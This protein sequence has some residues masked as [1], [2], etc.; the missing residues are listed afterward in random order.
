MEGATA[1]AAKQKAMS[2][3]FYL[4]SVGLLLLPF[5][6]LAADLEVTCVGSNGGISCDSN[7]P[8]GALFDEG[9]LLP[10]DTAIRSLRVNNNYD[11]PCGF[12][13]DTENEV[14]G[15]FSLADRLWTVIRSTVDRFGISDGSGGATNNKTMSNVFAAGP[16]ALGTLAANSTKNYEWA[17]TFDETT[18]NDWQGEE[19]TFD[20]DMTFACSE[21]VAGGDGDEPD[22][23]PGMDPSPSPSPTPTVLGA[24]SNGEPPGGISGLLDRFP[25]A[26]AESAAKWL[27][28]EGKGWSRLLAAALAMTLTALFMVRVARL[29][30]KSK[31][32]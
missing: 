22:C 16:I 20:F 14:V 6:A 26:G 31:V 19:T 7:P 17:V 27:A 13:L 18:G 23:C 9:N 15:T 10:G 30:G 21:G 24:V 32:K 29:A 1:G 2:K 28:G 4:L 8:S 3:V 5:A 12:V 25:T 11:E